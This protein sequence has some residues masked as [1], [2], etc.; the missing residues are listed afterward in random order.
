MI[1]AVKAQRIYTSR[2]VPSCAAKTCAVRPFI[3]QVVGELRAANPSG[4]PRAHE[5][6]C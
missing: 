2:R 3:V 1:L 4:C 5:A 6:K